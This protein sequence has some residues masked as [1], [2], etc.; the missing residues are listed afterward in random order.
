MLLQP[1]GFP[2]L[3]QKVTEWGCMQALIDYEGWRKWRGFMDSPRSVS[4]NVNDVASPMRTGDRESLTT[5]IASPSV[6]RTTHNQD[7]RIKR[8]Q[9][10]EAA[11]I[12]REDSWG[13][14]SGSAD[15]LDDP[16]SPLS[17]PD[18]QVKPVVHHTSA[19]ADG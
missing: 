4:P 8:P 6:S 11:E 2:W 5:E 17:M 3:E 14:G 13:S 10:P 1:V 19:P 15:T 16:T 9:L 18:I 12:L 7:S